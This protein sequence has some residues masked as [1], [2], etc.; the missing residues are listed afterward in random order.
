LVIEGKHYIDVYLPS[1]APPRVYI[2][3]HPAGDDA[4]ISDLGSSACHQW[5]SCEVD[6]RVGKTA[7]DAVGLHLKKINTVHLVGPDRY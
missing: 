1:F 6:V 5:P 2:S 7:S 4:G 3:F